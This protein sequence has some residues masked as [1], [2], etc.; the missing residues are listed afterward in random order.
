MPRRLRQAML[1]GHL[2]TTRIHERVPLAAKLHAGQSAALLRFADVTTLDRAVSLFPAVVVREYARGAGGVLRIGD[3]PIE[4]RAADFAT[5]RIA[6][7]KDGAVGPM[8]G[9]WA[10]DA[11][12]ANPKE[13]QRPRIADVMGLL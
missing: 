7:P 10:I 3:S 13:R 6:V 2:A 11:G 1:S 4:V 9:S 5:A 8:P 12:R